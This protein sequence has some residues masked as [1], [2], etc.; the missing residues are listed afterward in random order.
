LWCA[1]LE[2]RRLSARDEERRARFEE[3]LRNRHINQMRM[4]YPELDDLLAQMEDQVNPIL[5]ITAE[6]WDTYTNSLF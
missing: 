2:E 5:L 3:E 6:N 4:K 1:G